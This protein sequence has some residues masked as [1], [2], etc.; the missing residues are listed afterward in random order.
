MTV[1]LVLGILA[2][3]ALAAVGFVVVIAVLG[4]PLWFWRMPAW[5][6]RRLAQR[7]LVHV[8]QQQH[9]TATNAR[10]VT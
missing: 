7:G 1:H 5:G 10:M 8:L 4:L 6:R 9:L 3:V 2:V